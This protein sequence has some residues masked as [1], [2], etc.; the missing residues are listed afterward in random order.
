[1]GWGNYTDAVSCHGYYTIGS[2]AMKPPETYGLQAEMR[3]L[4]T[5]MAA[6][7]IKPGA[8]LFITET[9]VSY[10]MGSMYSAT[11]PTN[12]VLEQHAEAVVR[13]HLIML[14]EGADTTLLFYSADYMENVGFGMYFNLSMSP[15]HN[16]GSNSIA[17][18]PATMA[19]AAAARLVDGS[20][21]LGALTN[22]PTGGYG[23]AFRLADNAHA[24]VAVWAH[25]SAFDASIAYA[26]VVDAPGTSGTTVMF[27][28][29]GNPRSVNYTNGV[30]NVTLS[31]MPIYVRS[32]N[33]AAVSAHAQAP[34]GYNTGF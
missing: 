12:Q 4:R 23:Y 21:S 2:S 5:T 15:A 7:H 26:V 8:K 13:T 34:Q 3:Q 1:M 16:F 19:M 22:L 27:D 17:P 9:G 32:S 30:V 10:G 24:M 11:S 33:I 31:E 29:M 20:R 18:K 28:S 14:G 25:N 6:A